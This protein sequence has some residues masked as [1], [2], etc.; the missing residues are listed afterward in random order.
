[1]SF[2]ETNISM[3][4]LASRSY[5]GSLLKLSLLLLFALTKYSFEEICSFMNYA[6][7]HSLTFENEPFNLMNVTS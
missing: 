1:M 3:I 5:R 6:N 7:K 4:D 2:E